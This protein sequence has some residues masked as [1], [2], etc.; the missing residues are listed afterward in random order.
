MRKV[1]GEIFLTQHNDACDVMGVNEEGCTARAR[2][3][4]TIATFAD[5]R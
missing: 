3:L 2:E 5:L 4:A 1:C